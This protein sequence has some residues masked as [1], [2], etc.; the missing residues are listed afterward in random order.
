MS[1]EQALAWLLADPPAF[2]RYVL[3]TP[4]RRYQA[5]ALRAIGRAIARREGGA[6]ALMCARQAGK[7]EVSAHLEAW[8]LTRYQT[9]R[10]AQIVKTAPTLRPQLANSTRRLEQALNNVLTRGQWR[11]EPGAIRLGEARVLFLSGA[12]TANVVGATATLALE[13]DEAQDIAPEKHDRDFA[14]MAATTNAVR[15]YYGTAW[16]D[17][18]LLARVIADL[19]GRPDGGR[20]VFVVPWQ[21]VAEEAPDYGRFVESERARL[22]AE[23]PLFR[24]QYELE[25]IA[26]GGR[27]FDA[28]QLAQLR[29]RHA[30]LPGPGAGGT[31]VAGIDVAGEDEAAVDASLRA[32][33]PRKDSTVVTIARVTPVEVAA[34]VTEPA[35]EVVEHY[36]WT[37]H[38]HR[39]QC[40]RLVDLLREVWGVRRACV[41]ATGVG[42]GLASFLRTAL[43]AVVEPVAFSAARKSEL[44]YAL[45]A[46]VNSGRLKLYAEPALGEEARECWRELEATRYEVGSS[47]T[48]RWFVPEAEGH[49]DFV[50]SL[51]LTVAAAADVGP[52]PAAEALARPVYQARARW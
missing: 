9:T 4:P 24:T 36:W 12:P 50:A 42:A 2:S 20:R 15:V 49:D 25:P 18:T 39:E 48:L 28:R 46:A 14:P 47:S 38:D 8:A 35:L 6:F 13:C 10:G 1:Q 45:L 7:N 33:R 52:E 29:G 41:D 26:G 43:G 40:A 34:G 3:R 17:A 23:H 27:L 51:A 31:F 5:E 11:R 21:R 19:R 32:A 30:R 37:G 16:T 44:G 22:G